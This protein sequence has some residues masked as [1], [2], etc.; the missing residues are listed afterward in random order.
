MTPAGLLRVGFADTAAEKALSAEF[1]Q[2]AAT[3]ES[4]YHKGCVPSEEITRKIVEYVNSNHNTV[5]IFYD[6]E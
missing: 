6:G 1:A 4:P 3:A 5:K 2:V